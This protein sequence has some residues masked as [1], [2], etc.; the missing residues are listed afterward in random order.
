MRHDQ[1]RATP[2][3]YLRSGSDSRRAGDCG[4]RPVARSRVRAPE[5]TRIY[6]A[7]NTVL[8]CRVALQI[9]LELADQLRRQPERF[10]L[11]LE[12]ARNVRRRWRG[13]WFR[14]LCHCYAPPIGRGWVK[15]GMHVL[16]RRACAFVGAR[17]IIQRYSPTQPTSRT[18][19][20]YGGEEAFLC[21]TQRRQPG[22][23]VV[24]IQGDLEKLDAAGDFERPLGRIRVAAVA[25]SQAQCGTR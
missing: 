8:L 12:R 5:I 9:L 19:P 16:S 2:E 25:Q 7:A 13:L 6:V 11:L 23:A 21:L 4:E 18:A 20:A 24:A 22:G 3:Q 15:F 1:A 14:G 17:A 10:L